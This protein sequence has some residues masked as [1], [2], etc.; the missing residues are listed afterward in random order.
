MLKVKF[1][2]GDLENLTFSKTI[3]TTMGYMPTVDINELT[4]YV[5]FAKTEKLNFIFIKHFAF[6]TKVEILE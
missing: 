2:F 5:M 6:P 3:L 4:I 1:Y